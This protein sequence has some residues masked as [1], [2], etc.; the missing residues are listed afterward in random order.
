MSTA[1]YMENIS[2]FPPEEGITGGRGRWEDNFNHG[3]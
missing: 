1:I 3:V 2:Q